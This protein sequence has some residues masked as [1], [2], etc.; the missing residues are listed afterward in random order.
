[1]VQ[2]NL[3]E[4]AVTI[5]AAMFIVFVLSVTAIHGAALLMRTLR[6]MIVSWGF[7]LGE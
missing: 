2:L 6:V 7:N 4:G 1:M 5:L 3:I